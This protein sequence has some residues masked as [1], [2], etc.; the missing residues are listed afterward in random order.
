M[1]KGPQHTLT[2]RGSNLRFSQT[3]PTESELQF[4]L[5]GVL[6]A[7]RISRHDNA[8]EIIDRFGCT[9][10]LYNAKRVRSAMALPVSGTSTLPPFI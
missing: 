4:T 1:F 5:P 9:D 6:K 2:Q 7:L 3:M 8:I 10:R